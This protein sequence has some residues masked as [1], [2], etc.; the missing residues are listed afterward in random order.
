LYLDPR[1]LRPWNL[2]GPNTKITSDYIRL[3]DNILNDAV[4][5]NETPYSDNSIELTLGFHIH[6]PGETGA[7]GM[8]LWIIDQPITRSGPAF[9]GPGLYFIF[10]ILTCCLIEF[11]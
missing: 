4:I 3:T 10:L 2:Y 6:S 11:L 5:S 8:V 7:D 9:G 1:G